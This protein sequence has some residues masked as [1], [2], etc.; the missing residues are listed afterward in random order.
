M[1][2]TKWIF[3]TVRNKNRKGVINELLMC[4]NL[5]TNGYETTVLNDNNPNWDMLLTKADRKFYLESKL[6][7]TSHITG[8]FY[9]EYWNY[10]FSRKTGINND[11]LYTLYSHT[12]Y[13]IQQD[14]YFYL[15]GT[16]KQYIDAIGQI[17][18]LEPTKIRNYDNTYYGLSGVKG[19]AAYIVNKET[20]LSYFQGY[21][22]ELEFKVQ[23]EIYDSIIKIYVDDIVD[24]VILKSQKC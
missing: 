24:Y 11:N 13:D 5:L 10:T 2:N 12:Y 18:A 15:I 17:L 9:F 16:R 22:K 19:D 23:G 1:N 14:K 8:N 3:D 6:D 21:N 7:N 4:D 20:F